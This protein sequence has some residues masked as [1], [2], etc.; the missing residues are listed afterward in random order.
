[1]ELSDLCVRVRVSVGVRVGVLVLCVCVG[2]SSLR[3]PRSHACARGRV[4]AW[5]L[6]VVRGGRWG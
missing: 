4:G 3:A 6:Q 1:M 5:H 2:H